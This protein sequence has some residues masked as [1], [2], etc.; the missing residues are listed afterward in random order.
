[1]RHIWFLIGHLISLTCFIAAMVCFFTGDRESF[2]WMLVFG[3]I[4]S[5]SADLSEV[6]Y[7]LKKED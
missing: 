1:M 3:F 5:V 2:R 7:L 4:T 6:K